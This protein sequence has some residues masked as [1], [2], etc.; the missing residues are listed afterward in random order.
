MRAREHMKMIKHNLIGWLPRDYSKPQFMLVG[1]WLNDVGFTS[2]TFI[3]I[4]C[5]DGA[6]I[7]KSC[8]TAIEAY[9]HLITQV[10]PDSQ[11]K[12]VTTR[13]KKGIPLPHIVLNGNALTQHGFRTGDIV[14]T[15]ITFGTIRIKRIDLS[16][17]EFNPSLTMKKHV[18][19]VQHG[20]HKGQSLPRIALTGKWLI[21]IGFTSKMAVA[22]SYRDNQIIFK[23]H[24]K[25]KRF[26]STQ[27]KPPIIAINHLS[28]KDL[29]YF[30]LQGLWLN[31]LGFS[32]ETPFL[33]HYTKGLIQL[34]RFDK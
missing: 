4:T 16:P 25:P 29:P 5:I 24:S 22:V 13:V 28:T 31:D 2:G 21:D 18:F 8:G 17:F 15:H 9:H 20:R 19:H 7:L 27:G 30:R 32:I 23:L 26:Q 12:L 34:T 3:D 11:I 10:T 14:E 1:H 6:L 33:V